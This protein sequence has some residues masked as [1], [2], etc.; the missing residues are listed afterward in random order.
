[1]RG[2]G[3]GIIMSRDRLDTVYVDI[4]A[5][6]KISHISRVNLHSRKYKPLNVI[7]AMHTT[8][9]KTADILC[10]K[11]FTLLQN[12]TPARI[13]TFTVQVNWIHYFSLPPS[14]QDAD[15]MIVLIEGHLN[16]HSNKLTEMTMCVGVFRTKHLWD[17]QRRKDRMKKGDRGKKERTVLSCIST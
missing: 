4:L 12:I 6:D 10:S 15:L 11:L 3:G 17:E 7:R 5:V 8:K 13:S 1:M 9:I 14:L 2:I 16:V